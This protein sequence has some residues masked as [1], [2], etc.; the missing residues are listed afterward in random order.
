MAARRAHARFLLV[1]K[2]SPSS[3]WGSVTGIPLIVLGFILLVSWRQQKVKE[4]VR[5]VTR[6]LGKGL[7]EELQKKINKS[8]GV[9]FKG[10]PRH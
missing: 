4:I 9:I 1:A 10:S 2:R 8:S 7:H 5:E 3:C 6:E